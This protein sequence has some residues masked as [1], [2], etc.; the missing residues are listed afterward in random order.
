[1]VRHWAAIAGIFQEE[2]MEGTGHRSIGALDVTWSRKVIESMGL[3]EG[4][5]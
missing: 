5:I 3:K 1:L 2:V 4:H